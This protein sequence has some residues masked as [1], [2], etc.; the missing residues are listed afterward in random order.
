M[1]AHRIV[2][3]GIAVGIGRGEV[4]R[5]KAA[6]QPQALRRV[7][8][9]AA[10]GACDFE[11]VEAA[12]LDDLHAAQQ[13]LSGLAGKARRG[14]AEQQILPRRVGPVHQ[15]AQQ[16]KQLRQTLHFVDD[17][18]ASQTFERLYRLLETPGMRRVFEVEPVRRV[19][20]QELSCER[21][22]AGL[23]RTDEHDS[24]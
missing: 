14:T 3:P 4:R 2:A 11:Q 9:P 6:A 21:A 12:H 17:D 18:K 15:H 23:A 1:H 10:A 20:I 13:R 16:R 19:D 5:R 22:L 8:I 24:A 7:G